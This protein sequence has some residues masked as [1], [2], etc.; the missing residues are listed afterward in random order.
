AHLQLPGARYRDG[1]GDG[2]LPAAAGETAIGDAGETDA[3][4]LAHDAVGPVRG[5]EERGGELVAA[6]RARHA[7]AD[8]LALLAHRGQFVPAPDLHAQF[9]RA[10]FQQLFQPALRNGERVQGIV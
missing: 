9:P 7:D 8:P 3:A 2:D 6:T 1:R 10:L 5:D 4:L